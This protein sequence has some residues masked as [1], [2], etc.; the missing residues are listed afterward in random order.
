MLLN[1]F[2]WLVTKRP[3]EILTAPKTPILFRV[4]SC[5]TTGS[6]FSGG[7]HMTHRDPCCWKWYSSSNQRSISFLFANSR[8]FF[9]FRL[10]LRIRFGND[11]SGFTPS[12][13]QMS[14]QPLA[15]SY[16]KLNGI[17]LRK[18]M[19]EKFS[20]PKILGIFKRPGRFSQIS[21]NCTHYFFVKPAWTTRTSGIYNACKTL[22]IKMSRPILNGSWTMSQYL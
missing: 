17:F 18:M 21:A 7:I 4:G 3:S 13:P 22:I 8:S 6:I 5:N 2:S 9:I 11:R 19:A 16:T 20:I 15:L 10:G 12:E 1:V 14:K